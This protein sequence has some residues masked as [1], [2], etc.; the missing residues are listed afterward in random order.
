MENMMTVLPEKSTL[1]NLQKFC[2]NDHSVLQS[3]KGKFA[4]IKDSN[5]I[6]YLCQ[7]FPKK[8]LHS[9][10]C[11]I[12][13]SVSFYNESNNTSLYP[14]KKPSP[15]GT[16]TVQIP[17]IN[18]LDS[19]ENI[20]TVHVSVVFNTPSDVKKWKPSC[21]KLCDLVKNLL[22]LFVL[23]RGALL[24]LDCV[25]SVFDTEIEYILIE[26]IGNVNFGRIVSN[27][28]VK[29]KQ[30]MSNTTFYQ[31]FTCGDELPFL[32]GLDHHLQTLTNL[33]KSASK[34]NVQHHSVYKQVLIVGPSG[35]GKTAMVRKVARDCGMAIKTVVGPELNSPLP[36][37]AERA[38]SKVFEECRLLAQESSGCIL[39]LDQVECLC[40]RR[41]GS[42]D[43]H[44][45]RLSN[46]L[47][48]LLETVNSTAGLIVVGTSSRPQLLDPAVRRPGRFD[49]EI[50]IGVSSEV[51]RASIVS[52][53][54]R[55][56]GM[57]DSVSDRVARW[58]PGFVGADLALLAANVARH[59]EKQGMI[60]SHD[61][62]A[63][64][65]PCWR[66][67]VGQ[68]RPSC[69]RGQLGVVAPLTGEGSLD[70]LGGVDKVKLSLLQAIQWPLEHAEAFQRM[71]LPQPKGVL[72]YGPPGCAKTSLV[73]AVASA[74]NTTFL[75]VSAAEIYSPYVGDA[76]R[77]VSELFHR[78][79]IGAPAI[80][81]IDEID[82]LVGCRGNR[83]RG[84][85]ERILTAFLTEMD[86]IGVRLDSGTTQAGVI[87]VAA[88]NRPDV[89][90]PALTRPGR[91]DRIVY[92]GPPDVN[93]RLEILQILTKRTPLA[94]DVDLSVM[95]EKTDLFSGADLAQLC[96]EAGLEAL[97]IDGMS[98]TEVKQKH[99]MSALE[100]MSP[101]LSRDQVDQYRCVM[102][103]GN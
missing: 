80:L 71:G 84:S 1:F 83:E 37:E 24:T 48:A 91:F 94:N 41:D 36:G 97:T 103:G 29:I 68:L 12:N 3:S 20:K 11:T 7:I 18:I 102:A 39:L 81:F 58:T 19:V 30:L 22:K 95:A 61:I 2:I 8:M 15:I 65:L 31:L 17:D 63:D 90:D 49:H 85:Q 76:E 62:E 69:L 42:S 45:I 77:T 25:K 47:F 55:Q 27:S 32:G 28:K 16:S 40:G 60:M 101:S 13:K 50:H 26:S 10:Y 51:E 21:A 74:T 4:V 59:M 56:M 23:K 9:S 98:V 100:S 78:A 34:S 35:C 99:W 54:T 72:L 70:E 57:S 92:V 5:D 38:L 53:V 52:A 75:A 82:A 33:V 73:R 88:T 67:C 93:Q 79:R 43:G 89:L 6:N 46:Q 64:I 96:K 66:T 86:G 44:I 87:V 14:L